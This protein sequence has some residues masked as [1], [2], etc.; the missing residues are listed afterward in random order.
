MRGERERK[1]REGGGKEEEGGDCP[2]LDGHIRSQRT[3]RYTQCVCDVFP[4]RATNVFP[5]VPPTSSLNVFP[6]PQRLPRAPNVFPPPAPPMSSPPRCQCLSPTFPP[7]PRRLPSPAPP[8]GFPPPPPTCSLPRS[9]VF[10]PPPQ[11]LPSPAPTSS[12]PRPQRLPS[13]AP[14]SA[15][16]HVKHL[17]LPALVLPPWFYSTPARL[18]A[19]TYSPSQVPR[20]TEPSDFETSVCSDSRWLRVQV[21]VWQEEEREQDRKWG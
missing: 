14:T 2:N 11:R 20:L 9:N 3:K 13:P 6:A 1:R 8:N 12:L 5:P 16:P 10:P 19:L 4:P 21:C 7:H 17:L 15:M 18:H